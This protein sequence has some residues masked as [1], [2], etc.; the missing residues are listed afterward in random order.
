VHSILNITKIKETRVIT[1]SFFT[2]VAAQQACLEI[3]FS[4]NDKC[5]A[6]FNEVALAQPSTTFFIKV[7]DVPLDVDKPV[8]Q[9]IW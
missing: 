8:F 6:P 7:I 2:E 3:F 9:Q 4:E 1:A 5:F